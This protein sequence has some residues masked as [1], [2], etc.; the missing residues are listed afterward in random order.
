MGGSSASSSSTEGA[1]DEVNGNP[2]VIPE[3]SG[4]CIS[5]VMLD[6]PVF[7]STDDHW[8]DRVSYL[9]SPFGDVVRTPN[10]RVE[11]GSLEYDICDGL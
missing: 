8:E 6:R 4:S 10:P 2:S 5:G 11:T 3:P 9:T 1:D 7:A